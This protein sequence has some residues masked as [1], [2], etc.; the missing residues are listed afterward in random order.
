MTADIAENV[1]RAK[2]NIA[3]AAKRAGRAAEDIYLVGA[4]KMNDASRVREAI[5]AGL[6]ICGENR[7]QEILEK[8]GK[9][10]VVFHMIG[11][12]QTNKVKYI[13][14]KVACIQSV[15]SVRLMDE[16]E[17]Q[18]AKRNIVMTIFFEINAGREPDKTGVFPEN[19]PELLAHLPACPHLKFDGI[20]AMVPNAPAENNLEYY[21]QMKSLYDKLKGEYG[22]T[23]LS[24]G[25]SND[26]AEAAKCGANMIRVGTA[27]F[28]PR[29]TIAKE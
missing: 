28:G 6:P 12:L 2:E 16:I 15:D 13:A 18:C 5:C 27:L 1:A 4:T 7:V 9:A 22:I 10:D 26:Y 8:Y 14:D 17:R 25:M 21:L 23:T 20:M 24:M 19:L 29:R 3:L 11:H